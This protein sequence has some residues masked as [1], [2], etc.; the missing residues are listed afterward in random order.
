MIRLG[1]IGAGAAVRE[2]HWP[3]LQKLDS[4]V[5]VVRISNATIESARAFAK[6]VGSPKF[7]CD[8]R[9]LLSDR[10]IDAVLI[11]VP[12][13]FNAT[14]LIDAVNAGKH[15]LA[16]KPIAATRREAL[17]VLKTCSKS[18]RVVAIAENF[19]FRGDLRRA[20]ELL[21]EWAIGDVFAF[22]L[23]VCF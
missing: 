16:E 19:R 13:E 20:R 4:E 11:A 7:G 17:R 22:Q 9:E 2:L 1:I 23:Q 3:V 18:N 14:V 12:I 6:S 5:Q 10:E 21:Q 15:V 8:Y